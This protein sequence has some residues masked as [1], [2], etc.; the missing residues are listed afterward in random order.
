MIKAMYTG[1]PEANH[2]SGLAKHTPE[3]P[4]RGIST[5]AVIKLITVS[6]AL[7]TVGDALRPMPCITLRNMSMRPSKK[8]VAPI[9]F[10]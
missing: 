8:T 10:R 6:S 4:M 7:H 1:I 3:K 2:D 9:Y 5:N